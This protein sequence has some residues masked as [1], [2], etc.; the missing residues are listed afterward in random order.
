M[1]S[2][3]GACSGRARNPHTGAPLEAKAGKLQSSWAGQGGFGPKCPHFHHVL[4]MLTEFSASVGAAPWWLLVLP[5]IISPGAV[6][7]LLGW[8]F[9]S[10]FST[11]F[12]CGTPGNDL[13]PLLL[14]FP[15]LSAITNPLIHMA[16]RHRNHSNKTCKWRGG[17]RGKSVN[18]IQTRA[19]VTKIQLNSNFFSS[20][21]PGWCF[22]K[23]AAWNFVCTVTLRFHQLHFPCWNIPTTF[24]CPWRK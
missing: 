9:S 16:P 2:H 17:E 19:E 22:P 23:A 24:C 6:W 12:L 11:L 8:G 7:C 4:C 3:F 18:K 21:S 1:I 5:I 14:Q 20:F 15:S 10:R 13:V